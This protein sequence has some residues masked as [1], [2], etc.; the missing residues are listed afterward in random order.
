[1]N[2]VNNITESLKQSVADAAAAAKAAGKINFEELPQFVLEVPKDKA[3]GDFASNI[4]LVLAKQAKMRPRDIATAIAEEI[5]DSTLVAKVEIAGAGFLNFFLNNSWLY[6]VLPLVQKQDE[7]YGTSDFGHG[8]KVQ[9]EFVS[10]N[11]T[12]LLHMG[13]AAAVLWARHWLMF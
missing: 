8:E 10:A 1:M 5:S 13:N 12:G 4:A 9:V 11:P 3:H 2:L 6:D 7:K